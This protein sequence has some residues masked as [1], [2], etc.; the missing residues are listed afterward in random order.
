M[1]TYPFDDWV[2]EV[3]A[4]D[5]E[6][7]S[8]ITDSQLEDVA[9]ARSAQF[10]LRHWEGLEVEVPGF[11]RASALVSAKS[12]LLWAVLDKEGPRSTE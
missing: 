3:V 5:P 12:K 6:E 2:C 10:L 4:G 11:A 8:E 7:A 9:A 1:T